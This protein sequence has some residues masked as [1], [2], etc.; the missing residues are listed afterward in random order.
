M[1]AVSF[2][3]WLPNPD[4]TGHWEIEIGMETKFI[5]KPWFD[6]PN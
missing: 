5:Q 6:I 2:T 4:K 3:V 1:I